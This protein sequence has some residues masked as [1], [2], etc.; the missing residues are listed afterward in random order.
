MSILD[1]Q[2]ARRDNDKSIVDSNG[3]KPNIP[4]FG[5]Y[6][7]GLPFNFEDS[8]LLT[9]QG[10]QSRDS[11]EQGIREPLLIS[12]F[13][14]KILRFPLFYPEDANRLAKI[15]FEDNVKEVSPPPQNAIEVVETTNGVTA[16][17]S[18]H[19]S[20]YK[21]TGNEITL[22]C[23]E[24][25]GSPLNQLLTYHLSGISDSELGHRH[26]WGFEGKRM[27][28]A[29]SFDFAV[30]FLGPSGRPDDV[31][32]SYLFC[33]AFPFEER[34]SHY[35]AVRGEPGSGQ[36]FDIPFKGQFLTG[37]AVDRLARA[38]VAGSG[39]Y[40]ET[41]EDIRLPFALYDKITDA[42]AELRA[43]FADTFEER[44]RDSSFE[45]LDNMGKVSN[46]EMDDTF[47]NQ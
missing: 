42:T 34:S 5:S 24:T 29:Y 9:Q 32:Y 28:R 15:F 11:K 22:K 16:Q 26:L 27:L 30:V 35:T 3:Y 17:P 41:K 21:K 36:E 14:I 31:E 39:L 20:I 7:A 44:F 33:N 6:R 13:I 38:I 37:T 40:N 25:S 10:I 46:F 8:T 23:P 47:E 1:D 4:G 2:I 45:S 18:V 12:Q 43:E 19:A